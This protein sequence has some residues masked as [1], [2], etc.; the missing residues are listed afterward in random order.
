MGYIYQIYRTGIFI[1]QCFNLFITQILIYKLAKS[2]SLHS[3]ICTVVVL[4]LL[5]FSFTIQGGNSSEEWSLPYLYMGLFLTIDIESR[6][7]W[8][9][10]IYIFALGI[11]AAILFWIRVNNMSIISACIIY[12]LLLSL[13]KRNKKDLKFI[14]LSFLSGF[15]LIT[16][17]LIVYFMFI[18]SLYDM[19]YSSL[20]FN[21]KYIEYDNKQDFFILTDLIKDW[22]SWFTFLVF[23]IMLYLRFKDIRIVIGCSC[24]LFIALLS[25]RIGPAYSHYMT[26]NLPL[27]SLG[28]IFLFV[29]EQ[30]RIN[31]SKKLLLI[32]SFLSLVGYIFLKYNNTQYIQS[33]DDTKF[34][35]NA[36]DIASKIPEKESVFGYC[37]PTSFWLVS[38]ITPCY[39][40]FAKQEWH[41]LHD[42]EILKSINR[43]IDESTPQ[44]I[45]I[46]TNLNQVNSLN[47][48][49]F[50][51]INQ[52]YT[53]VYRNS[54]LILY[55][56][57]S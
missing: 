32:I 25:T 56:E 26:L 52:L 8:R 51:S 47:P 48:S 12:L 44:W 50:I 31:Q 43:F 54:D 38:D 20:L 36:L 30:K 5:V 10:Y 9:R 7:I 14:F 13:I 37:I 46:P 29:R 16:V 39:P 1:L 53:E 2:F 34:I 28:L 24:L 22:L 27:F 6:L 42:N 21:F 3:S 45:I 17:P 18:G 40:F 23:S 15:L 33:Q 19:I 11:F 41:G 49:F 4:S 57:R 35:K 55:K